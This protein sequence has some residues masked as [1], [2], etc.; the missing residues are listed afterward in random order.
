MHRA[1]VLALVLLIAAVL[2]PPP[3]AAAPSL[4]RP[5]SP[6]LLLAGAASWDPWSLLR[7]WFGGVR[8]DCGASADPYGQCASA[9]P[10]AGHPAARAPKPRS[11]SRPAAGRSRFRVECGGSMDPYGQCASAAPGSRAGHGM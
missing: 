6:A 4:P 8:V 2:A 7:Q 1:R 3:A 11:S 5:G 9:T 10:G